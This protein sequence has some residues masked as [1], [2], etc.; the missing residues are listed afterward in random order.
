MKREDIWIPT[1]SGRRFHLC[2]PQPEEICIE[3]IAHHLG[4][5]CRWT[6]AVREHW[7]V[8]QHCVLVARYLKH[9]GY[10]AN[11]CLAGLLHDA[12]EAYVNDSSRAMK[13][14]IPE[15]ERIEENIRL[16]VFAHFH[17]ELDDPDWQAVMDVDNFLQ[18]SEKIALLERHTVWPEDRCVPM[19]F[20]IVPW[21][22]EQAS[23]E[24]LELFTILNRK[25]NDEMS[26]VS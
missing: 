5:I 26:Q 16:A 9:S 25:Q 4:N 23:R 17:I 19:T 14:L 13:R 20:R 24:Y 11:V 7:S 6:G 2:D 22:P 1:Y 10:S 3:D 12:P 15:L 21:K 18:T 8:A